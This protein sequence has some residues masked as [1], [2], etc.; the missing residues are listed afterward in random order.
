MLTSEQLSRLQPESRKLLAQWAEEADRKLRENR[1]KSAKARW[2][3]P[4]SRAKMLNR[5]KVAAQKEQRLALVAAG[6]AV[7]KHCGEEKPLDEFPKGRKRRDGQQRYAYCKI[8]HRD[9]ARANYLKRIFKLTVEEYDKLLA[10]QDG[11]CAICRQ[12]PRAMRLAIDHDHKTGLVR[13][14]LCSFCN[15]ALATFLDE[16]DRLQRAVAYLSSPP[17]TQALGREHFGLVGRV[18]NKASTR[19]RLNG[20]LFE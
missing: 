18:G 7:C 8:C 5:P 19:K 16:L 2:K 14:L 9:V 20:R 4:V 3:D 6:V 15:R 12:A 11:L 17:A 13:G 1:S 10:F